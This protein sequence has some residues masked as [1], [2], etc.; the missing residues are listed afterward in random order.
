MSLIQYGNGPLSSSNADQLQVV[1]GSTGAVT[2]LVANFVSGQTQVLT[3]GAGNTLALTQLT[4]SGFP[5]N[6]I[7]G[8]T[9]T[10][11][12]NQIN[13]IE[14]TGTV[15]LTMPTSANFVAGQV[16]W[17]IVAT[18]TTVIINATTDQQF[19]APGVAGSGSLSTSTISTG[20]ITSTVPGLIMQLFQMPPI[21]PQTVGYTFVQATANVQLN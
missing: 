12:A 13:Y 1:N 18:A 10:L 2:N 16:L 9:G 21:T 15:T 19:A 7:T 17:V 20:N 5:V 4:F 8:A 6:A 3:V 14:G 11:V